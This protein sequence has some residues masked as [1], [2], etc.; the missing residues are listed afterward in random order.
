MI[1]RGAGYHE[2]CNVIVCDVYLPRP[3][4]SNDAFSLFR[5][6]LNR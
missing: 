3:E 1:Q 5:N 4:F 2:T 6:A